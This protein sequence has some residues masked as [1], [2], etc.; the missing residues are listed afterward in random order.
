MVVLF[1]MCLCIVK[2]LYVT[3][4]PHFIFAVPEVYMAAE[5]HGMVGPANNIVTPPCCIMIRMVRSNL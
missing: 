2:R 5:L 1:I 3:S 4:Y